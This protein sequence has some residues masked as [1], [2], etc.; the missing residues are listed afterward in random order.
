MPPA[1]AVVLLPQQ[2]GPHPGFGTAGP[3]LTHHGA[4]Q[5]HVEAGGGLGGRV[6]GPQPG[7][8]SGSWTHPRLFFFEAGVIRQQ[9]FFQPGPGET[10]GAETRDKFYSANGKSPRGMEHDLF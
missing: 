2:D 4:E 5:V 1:G 8:S 9:L 6:A 7:M 10:Q 3:K